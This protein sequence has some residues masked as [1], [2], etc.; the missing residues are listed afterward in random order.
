MPKFSCW[1]L[2]IDFKLSKNFCE[3]IFSC[4]IPNLLPLEGR[5]FWL[6]SFSLELFYLLNF[7]EPLF[8]KWPF[9]FGSLKFVLDSYFRDWY[10]K[11][12]I[13]Y[14]P[15]VKFESD[16]LFKYL[17]FA[18]SNKVFSFG[19]KLLLFKSIVFQLFCKVEFIEITELL[20]SLLCFRLDPLLYK[21]NLL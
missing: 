17:L 13:K 6:L 20:D 8:F 5:W 7:N 3:S 9:I 11:S 1:F 12:S 19:L 18:W 16:D 14:S 21:A 15:K 4:F 10:Y 2:L